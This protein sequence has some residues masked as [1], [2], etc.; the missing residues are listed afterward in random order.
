MRTSLIIHTY[1]NFETIFITLLR[2]TPPS[3]LDEHGQIVPTTLA[4]RSLV[5]RSILNRAMPP[6]DVWVIGV[7]ERCSIE[8]F[9]NERHH[10]CT[11][12][13][14]FRPRIIRERKEGGNALSAPER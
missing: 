9:R 5:S 1:R 4:F 12:N 14:L 6:V 2:S 10:D 11:Y 13:S 8:R 3:L 7:V